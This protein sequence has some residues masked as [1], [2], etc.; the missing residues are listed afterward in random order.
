MHAHITC[1]LAFLLAL[2]AHRLLAAD[3]APLQSGPLFDYSKFAFQPESWQKHGLSLQLVPWSGTNV[4]FLTTEDSL[5]PALMAIWVSRLDAGWQLFGQLT[6]RKPSPFRQSQGKVTIAAVPRGD[7]TCGAGCG[8]VG[9]TG[10]ELAMFYS[11][12]YAELKI[13][14][15]AMP[16]YVFYEMGRNYYTFGDRHSSFITGFAV[17]MRYVCMDAL[18]YEDTDA[19]TRKVIESVEERFATSK[20]SFLELFTMSTGVGEKVSRIKDANGKVIQP[21]DQPVRY[22][23]AMLR[24]RRENGGD[25]WVKRFFHAL[26]DCPKFKADTKEGALNQSWY[27]LLCANLAAQKDLSTVFGGEW[28]LPI[29]DVTRNALAKIDWKKNDL[30]L[31][32]VASAVTPGWNDS[33]TVEVK[34]IEKV[35]Q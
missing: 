18:G 35:V 23:S 32:E 27:W 2:A 26:A 7:L 10:I 3:I 30:T 5:D 24:L 6:G 14:P 29:T 13:H 19:K 4:I 28:R 25:A 31:Q 21:S 12:N 20:L 9:A 15:Y 17:F 8:Y 16:H 1:Q 33:N 11:H 34:P 22:A